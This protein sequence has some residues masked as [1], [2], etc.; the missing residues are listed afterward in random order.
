MTQAD[1]FLKDR[2]N[3][4]LGAKIILRHLY[5]CGEA[6]YLFRDGSVIYE[7]SYMTHAYKSSVEWAKHEIEVH[8]K[9]D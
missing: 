6:M 1:D 2:E 5:D 9:L 3:Q 4:S 7:T 8:R